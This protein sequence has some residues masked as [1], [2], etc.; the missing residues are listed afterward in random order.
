MMLNSLPILLAFL[1][2]NADYPR[3]E[4][5]VNAE[6]LVN[7]PSGVILDV[8]A[9]PQYLTGHI[10]GA[11]SVNG[12]AWGRAFTPSAS[13]DDWSKRLGEAGIDLDKPVIVYGTDDV[14]EPARIWWI[15]RFWGVKHAQL[16]NGGWPAYVAAGGKASQEEARP[17]ATKLKLTEHPDRLATKDQLLKLLAGAPPQLL[18][19]RSTAEFCGETTLAKRN[20]S[21]PGATHLEWIECLDP[22]TKRFKSPEELRKL[23]QEH[24]VDINKPAITYCQSG[25]RAS[26]VAFALELMGG[27]QIQNYYQSW[28]EWGNDPN[29]PVAKPSAKR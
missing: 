19:V 26:V 7:K 11:I 12:I 18:D 10:P 20:G 16:L 27:D 23:F 1:G 13:A 28:A 9:K 3:P 5:L 4:L 14:R 22:Q 21:I 25:G 15:L 17:T 29:T 6:S 8:R 2:A 24:K